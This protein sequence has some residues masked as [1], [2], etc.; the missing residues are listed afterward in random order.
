MIAYLLNIAILAG[1][2]GW[3]YTGV[4]QEKLARLYWPLWSLKILAGISLGLLYR[5]YYAGGDTFTFFNA[6]KELA[7]LALNDPARYVQFWWTSD[8][9]IITL[10]YTWKPNVF[11][12]K[13]VSLFNLLTANNYWLVSAYFSFASFTGAWSLVRA[14]APTVRRNIHIVLVGLFCL[15]SVVFW[16][17]GLMKESLA[18]GCICG[19]LAIVLPMYYGNKGFSVLRLLGALS[20]LFL[21]WQVKYYYAGLLFVTL[22]AMVVTRYINRKNLSYNFFYLAIFFIVVSSMMLFAISRLHP[23]FYLSRILQVIVDNYDAFVAH[24]EPDRV[25]RFHELSP[26]VFSFVENLP[27]ALVSGLFR[28][29][30]WEVRSILFVVPV[31]ENLFLAVITVVAVFWSKL[32]SSKKDAILVLGVLMY[33]LVM[34]VLLAFSTPNF[35]TLMRYKIGFLPFLV[36]ILMFGNPWLRRARY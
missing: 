29:F 1:L 20:L 5:H 19:I 22:F 36:M 12:V 9:A 17:S 11:F 25:I 23:N 8:S 26:H 35:G 16:S 32:P 33:S 30:V 24:S 14:L 27:L 28:P 21:L 7:V 15:P 10:P 3:L 13:V 31:L 6:G 18:L 34:A 2:S 4:R